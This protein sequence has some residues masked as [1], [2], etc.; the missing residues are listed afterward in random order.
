MVHFFGWDICSRYEAVSER[1]KA[2]LERE[3]ALFPTLKTMYTCSFLECEKYSDI[4]LINEFSS[5][6]SLGS[7]YNLFWSLT[8]Q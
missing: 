5:I 7:W 8:L 1:V 3:I 4:K 6:C 2:C